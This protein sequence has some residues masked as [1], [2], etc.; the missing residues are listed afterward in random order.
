MVIYE[1]NVDDVSVVE[2]ENDPPVPRYGYAPKALKVA[3][4]RMKPQSREIRVPWS[5]RGIKIGENARD[6]LAKG[7]VNLRCVVPFIETL[8][9]AM[10]EAADHLFRG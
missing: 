10:P 8:Q 7:S 6:F 5:P 2:P 4:Q 1:I 9:S 3:R